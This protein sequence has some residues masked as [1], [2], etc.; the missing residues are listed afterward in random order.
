LKRSISLLVVIFVHFVARSFCAKI[1]FPK[2][3]KLPQISGHLE[4]PDVY[5]QQEVIQCQR[6][7]ERAIAESSRWRP[8]G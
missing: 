2:E 7:K 8:W 6:K 4:K 3:M 1:K 5:G